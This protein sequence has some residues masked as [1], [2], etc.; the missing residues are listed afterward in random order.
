VNQALRTWRLNSPPGNLIAKL[1]RP[2]LPFLP[3]PRH[4]PEDGSSLRE[5]ESK[6]GERKRDSLLNRG[7]SEKMEN[8]G[9][10]ILKAKKD[11]PSTADIK[12]KI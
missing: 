8:P 9:G 7:L 11:T 4:D 1:R 3:Q 6:A 5:G 12:L 10:P 2:Y